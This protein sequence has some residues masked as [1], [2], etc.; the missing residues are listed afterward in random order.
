MSYIFRSDEVNVG[1]RVVVRR[2]LGN[3][4][5]SD[6]IGHITACD[7]ETLEIRPQSVGGF[8]STLP[9]ISIAQDAVVIIKKLSPRRVRN[10]EIRAIEI[11]T[12]AAFPGIAHE[13]T[14]DGQWLLRA[15]DGITERS[16]SAAPLGASA[17]LAAVPWD[18]ILS[19][20]QR[21]D[22]PVQVLLPERIARSAAGLCQ[23][24]AWEFG[25]EILVLT[26]PLPAAA[27]DVSTGTP[28]GSSSQASN[29]RAQRTPMSPVPLPLPPATVPEGFHAE[30]LEQPDAAWLARYN[31]RGT[32]LPQQALELL[33]RQ[34]QGILGFGRIVH[35]AT[36]RT[37][38]ITR[39]TI[40][41]GY[42]GFSAVEV[43]PDFRRQGLG[44]ALGQYMLHWGVAHGAHTAYLQVVASNVAG[45]KLYES[46]GFV[47]H[48][49]H[50]YAVLKD[51]AAF[52]V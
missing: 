50:H 7:P 24:P 16:N 3:G 28:A 8:P 13:W 11:A 41:D 4:V 21:H 2:D 9:S 1:D 33:Q 47:E 38:A 23:P 51:A 10:S 25:P 5:H 44:R 15:G 49:R 22:L 48:H 17:G 19:F 32:P 29:T 40:T 12:A 27:P 45:Q 34:I 18:E 30:V 31:F 36:Q 35:T 14:S 20:Y 37:V 43:D 46:L 52:Q 42:L 39:A 6:V 26:R